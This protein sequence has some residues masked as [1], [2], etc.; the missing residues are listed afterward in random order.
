[1]PLICAVLAPATL[2]LRKGS[3]LRRLRVARGRSPMNDRS[4]SPGK[5]LCSQIFDDLCRH[6]FPP[7]G[8]DNEVA[9]TRRNAMLRK[10][11]IAVA[12]VAALGVSSVAMAAGGHGGHGAAIS[13]GGGGRRVV[14]GGGGQRGGEG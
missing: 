4:G 12:G 1:M 9:T 8:V 10:T 2:R 14:L 13:S 11:L 5:I 7:S 3:W 6:F